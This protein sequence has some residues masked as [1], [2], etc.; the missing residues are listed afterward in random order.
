VR[1]LALSPDGRLLA[2]ASKNG[3]LN[4]WDLAAGKLLASVEQGDFAFQV[5]AFSPDGKTLA[6][7]GIQRQVQ[8]FKVSELL[9]SG[10]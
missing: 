8:L 6:T 10:R 2:S 3:F 4:L 9:R 7:G 1:S 5:V